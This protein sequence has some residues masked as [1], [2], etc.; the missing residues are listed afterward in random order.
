MAEPTL[1]AVR[2][3]AKLFALFMAAGA[4][5]K[6]RAAAERKIEAWLKQHGKTRADIPA[7]LAH[8]VADEESQQ[9][10]PPDP[11]AE[12]HRQQEP[13]ARRATRPR[14]QKPARLCASRV[15]SGDACPYSP[16][17]PA[18]AAGYLKGRH[19][20]HKPQPKALLNAWL[21]RLWR[22]WRAKHM[23]HQ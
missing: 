22:L 6:E 11:V 10:P 17:R 8:A 9:P 15:R 16:H 19:S 2:R 5:T 23:A 14:H 7:I 18:L 21:W 1:A 3:F 20:C 12:R 4:T 13:V